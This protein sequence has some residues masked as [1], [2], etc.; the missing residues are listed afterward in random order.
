MQEKIC[1]AIGCS[2][3]SARIRLDNIKR[4]SLKIPICQAVST[5]TRTQ[6][7]FDNHIS[8]FKVPGFLRDHR[9]NR[10]FGLWGLLE[11][12]CS[13]KK[14]GSLSPATHLSDQIFYEWEKSNGWVDEWRNNENDLLPICYDDFKRRRYF[15]WVTMD[16]RC[17][18]RH[19]QWFCEPEPRT[20]GPVQVRTEVWEVLNWTAVSLRIAIN[21]SVVIFLERQNGFGLTDINGCW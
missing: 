6:G 1:S 14:A 20:C 18:H 12:L 2:R 7:W 3:G 8:Q 4:C 15:K 11:A 19:F 21:G 16:C 10:S 9:V 5:E 13:N 17:M